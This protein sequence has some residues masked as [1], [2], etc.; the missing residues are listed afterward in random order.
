MRRHGEALNRIVVET[1][2]ADKH[3]NSRERTGNR[4]EKYID[5]KEEHGEEM[6]LTS[7]VKEK[8]REEEA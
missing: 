8:S 1:C 3:K 7:D 4:K 6:A 5:V 2:R